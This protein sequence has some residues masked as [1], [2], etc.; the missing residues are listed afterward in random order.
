MSF[1][2]PPF[3]VGQYWYISGGFLVTVLHAERGRAYV[4]VFKPDSLSCSVYLSEHID[5]P[6]FAP[7]VLDILEQMPVGYP[8]RRISDEGP[9]WGVG[10]LLFCETSMFDK[11]AVEAAAIQWMLKNQTP[12]SQP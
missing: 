5:R 6:V 8:L 1:P 3:E 10:S 4:N 11:S 2:Q 12:A 9:E 7:D